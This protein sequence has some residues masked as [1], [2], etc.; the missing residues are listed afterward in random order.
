VS[1]RR[2]VRAASSALL[3]ASAAGCTT[4]PTPSNIAAAPSS[5][6]TAPNATAASAAAAS[7]A[8]ASAPRTA[9]TAVAV[10]ITGV[11][12]RSADGALEICPGESVRPCPGVRVRGELAP[13]LVSTRER[14][15]VVRLAG[16]YDGAE[17]VLSKAELVGA[18]P[19]R[20]PQVHCAAPLRSTREQSTGRASAD[21][22]ERRYPER[23]AGLWWDRARSLYTVWLTGDVAD[24]ERPALRDGVCV[25]GGASFSAR[26]LSASFERAQQALSD[27]GVL[28]VEGGSDVLTNRVQLRVEH[29][30]RTTLSRVRAVAG[31]ELTSFIELTERPLADLPPA[32]ARGDVPLVTSPMRS[33]TAMMHALGHFAVRLDEAR[34]CVFL[35]ADNGERYLPLWP[36][37]YA[38]FTS[39]LRIV[40]FDDVEVARE[41]TPTAFG[42]GHLPLS[43][44]LRERA[45][46]AESAWSGAPSRR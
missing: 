27:S 45:C 19:R 31:V 34:R 28:L 1:A 38:A 39:P 9:P 24:V 4:P 30:D 11:V 8:A 35:E 21:E 15:L 29:I 22:L 20:A 23:F 7:A 16:T 36:F 14:P 25:V 44:E 17:L 37:G 42:G 40:D 26:E 32:P 43:P 5:A 33:S 10:T 3:A 18:P 46:G 6:V 13:E 2:G 41:G 12:T